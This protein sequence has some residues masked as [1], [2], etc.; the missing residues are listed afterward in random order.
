MANRAPTG[1]IGA[2]RYRTSYMLGG[3]LVPSLPVT[4]F[5]KKPCC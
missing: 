5:N 1:A 4:A 3:T 2:Y